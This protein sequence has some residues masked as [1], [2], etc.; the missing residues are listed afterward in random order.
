VPALHGHGVFVDEPEAVVG[1]TRAFTHLRS[2][3]LSPAE[4]ASLIRDHAEAA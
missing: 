3:A 1:F 4:S 2:L